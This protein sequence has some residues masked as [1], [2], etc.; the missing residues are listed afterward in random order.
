MILV[1]PQL[2]EVKYHSWSRV[3]KHALLSKNKFKFVNGDILEPTQE[4]VMYDAWK[5]YNVIVIS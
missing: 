1:T 5:R 4:D 3:M 2:N